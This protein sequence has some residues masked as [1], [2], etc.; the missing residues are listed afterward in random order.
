MHKLIGV[1]RA[2]GRDC[3][4]GVSSEVYSVKSVQTTILFFMLLRVCSPN[5]NATIITKSSWNAAENGC[6]CTLSS[7]QRPS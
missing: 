1:P 5:I 2:F 6:E 4:Y 7:L 3:S